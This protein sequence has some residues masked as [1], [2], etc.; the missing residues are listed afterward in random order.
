VFRDVVFYES[1]FPFQT[2]SQNQVI[3]DSLL[4]LVILIPLTN[5]LPNPYQNTSQSPQT[6]ASCI[7]DPS[8]PPLVLSPDQPDPFPSVT[9]RR[10]TRHIK[11]PLYLSDYVTPKSKTAYLIQHHCFLLALSS[12]YRALINLILAVYEPQF[13]HR[14]A[15]YPKWRQAMNEEIK[16]LEENST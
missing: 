10:S 15:P 12:P 16:A 13:Y 11:P 6:P 14:V 2:I 9:L 1:I 8:D 7:Q 3:L 4:D 5:T